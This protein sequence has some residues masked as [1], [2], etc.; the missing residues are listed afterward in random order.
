MQQQQQP[1]PEPEP[2]PEAEVEPEPARSPVLSPRERI[3]PE[4]ITEPAPD[5][6]TEQQDS[7]PRSGFDAWVSGPSAPSNPSPTP[8]PVAA[9]APDNSGPP[10]Q[11]P[12]VG[13][14]GASPSPLQRTVDS[15][16]ALDGAA[17]E[18]AERQRQRA[19]ASGVRDAEFEIEA[20]IA[21]S[22]QSSGLTQDLFAAMDYNQDG[23]ITREEFEVHAMAAALRNEQPVGGGGAA[24]PAGAGGAGAA[25]GGRY[26]DVSGSG[27]GS[28]WSGAKNATLR[29]FYTKND[30]FTKTGSGQT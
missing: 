3:V 29:H 28:S 20:K 19:E 6:T 23:V 9:P 4:V 1:A 30:L 24:V 5:V 8:S 11:A 12:D 15:V 26:G 7:K 13:G 21:S 27:T 10:V 14:D 25:A 17:A 22:A 18:I 16:D 2:E